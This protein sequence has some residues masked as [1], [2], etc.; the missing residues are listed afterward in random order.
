[1][2]RVFEEMGIPYAPRPD[3]SDDPT[4]EKSSTKTSSAGKTTL[5]V[6]VLREK[7]GGAK[8]RGV[9]KD[10]PVVINDGGK[11]RS[12]VNPNT[13]SQE[14]KDLAQDLKLN[15]K[16]RFGPDVGVGSCSKDVMGSG[17]AGKSPSDIPM[18]ILDESVDDRFAI[19]FGFSLFGEYSS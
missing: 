2:N 7:I 1:M 14:E 6:P 12:R 8:K 5:K 4:K 16:H 18:Y 10:S 17:D 3:P 11:K 13:T 9:R 19:E 15:R